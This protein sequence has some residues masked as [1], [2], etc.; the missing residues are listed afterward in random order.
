MP[1]VDIRIVRDKKFPPGTTKEILVQLYLGHEGVGMITP[2]PGGDLH[3]IHP[4]AI[5]LMT[6]RP[7]NNSEDKSMKV[8]QWKKNENGSR[9]GTYMAY[10]ASHDTII[11]P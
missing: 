11:L 1:K 4:K 8:K 10:N 6:K 2:A 7:L 3:C 9:F 5:S